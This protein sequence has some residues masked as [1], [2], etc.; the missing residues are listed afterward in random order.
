MSEDHVR[1]EFEDG[2]E[3]IIGALIR[4]HRA[5]GPGLMESTYEACVCREFELSAIHFRRQVRVP[6]TYRGLQIDCAYQMDLVVDRI[7]IELKSVNELQKIHAAQILTYMKLARLP[8]GLLINFNVTSLRNGI[9]RFD[10]KTEATNAAP[11][12]LREVGD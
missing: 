12:L 8:I 2:S 3:E 5:L 9:R 11:I 6:L 4:V 7:V 1:R 10:L